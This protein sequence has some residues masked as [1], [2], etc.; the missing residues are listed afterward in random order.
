MLKEKDRKL[1]VLYGSQTGTAQDVAER[2]GR[3]AYKR[4]FSVSVAPLDSYPL[5]NL[6]HEQMVIFIVATTGQGDPPDNMQLFW[7]FIMRRNLPLNSLSGVKFSVCGLGDSSYQKFN[8]VAKKLH[9][10][11]IQLGGQVIHPIGLADD[12]HD[13]GAEATLGPWLKSVCDKLLNMH[14]LSKGM[15]VIPDDVLCPSKFMITKVN[16]TAESLP[17]ETITPYSQH[18]PYQ[19]QVLSNDRVTAEDHWQDVR[20]MRLHVPQESIAYEPGDVLMVMPQNSEENVTEFCQLLKL[21]PS[22]LISFSLRDSGQTLPPALAKPCTVESLARYYLDLNS[23]PR[24]FFWEILANFT[25]SDL[26][27]EKLQEFLTPEGQ[28]ELFTYCHRPRRTILEVLADFPHATEHLPHD[29]IVDLFPALQP[30]AFSIASSPS[31][32]PNEMHLLMAVVEYRTKLQKPRLG[33]CSTWLASLKPSS[34]D[35]RI[36]VW[37]KK[38]M[39]KFPKDAPV[40]MV[41][42]GTGCAPFRSLIHERAHQGL[43]GALLFFGCRYQQK[44]F[45]CAREWQRLEEAG[46]LRV[47]TAFSRDQEDKIYVQHKITECG[48][49]IWD[50]LSKQGAW[51]YVAGNAKN[52]PDSVRD[53]LKKAAMTHGRL[54][55]KDACNFLLDLDKSGR[56]QAETWS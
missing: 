4:H 12:M 15:E 47:V 21:S 42:P 32:H 13:L 17:L 7:K 22:M 27:R 31:A 46:A 14:P 53:A 49:L 56:Y 3:L 52:M 40:I 2:M 30:R 34:R 39:M 6:I 33:T 9:K 11:L 28:D 20:L 1:V 8:F 36:P 50:L 5:V 44:D 45:L 29:Y 55:E 43:S 19:A 41:G 26:E 24:Q 54:S 23:R 48:S 35:V 51:F 16:E 25:T 38:G 18:N 37:L 10:R